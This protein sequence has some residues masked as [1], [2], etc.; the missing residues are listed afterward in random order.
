MGRTEILRD[1]RPQGAGRTGP[2]IQLGTGGILPYPR[3]LLSLQRPGPYREGSLP[4]GK[5]WQASITGHTAG[6]R[7]LWTTEGKAPGGLN[8]VLVECRPGAAAGTH[9]NSVR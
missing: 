9:T 4:T 7:E 5:G 6:L 8:W 2:G 1:S 3:P